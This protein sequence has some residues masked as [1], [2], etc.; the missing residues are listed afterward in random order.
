[1]DCRYRSAAGEWAVQWQC[2]DANT[3][4]LAVTV[5]FGCT[6]ELILPNWNGETG[7]D[8]IFADLQNGICRLQAGH[9]ELTYKTAKPLV[10]VLSSA[11]T[12]AE[13]LADPAAKALLQK[14]MPGITQLPAR[15]QN[16][17]MAALMRGMGH[18]DET[19]LAKIDAALAALA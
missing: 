16:L 4:T 7:N 14:M 11:N 18:A 8:P 5:P 13:L 10:R 12:M 6:A 15:M 1:M 19:V 2:V 17:P 3:L 9:Y